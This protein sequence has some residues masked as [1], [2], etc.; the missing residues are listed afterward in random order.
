[1]TRTAS[2]RRRK[3]APTNQVG[4]ENR[5]GQILLQPTDQPGTDHLQ[6]FHGL[7]CTP[8]G[9]EYG[10]NGSDIHLRRCSQ[11][12]RGRPSVAY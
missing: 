12:Q 2:T 5:N 1:M 8:C 11:C 4:Y 6:Y 3:S 10:A 7:R 9:N